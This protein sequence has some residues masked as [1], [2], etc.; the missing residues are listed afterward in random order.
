MDFQYISSMYDSINEDIFKS[1]FMVNATFFIK[2]EEVGEESTSLTGYSD[3]LDGRQ[4]DFIKKKYPSGLS[5]FYRV[6]VYPIGKKGLKDSNEIEQQPYGQIENYD[7]W[8]SCFTDT[9]KINVS[10][11]LLDYI[12]V[13]QIEGTKY[14][15]QS[16]VSESF[17]K[18]EVTHILLAKESNA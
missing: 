17:G 1:S 11:T 12:D 4:V 7:Y 8:V 5:P 10:N 15:V 9:I 18:K 6:K 3:F 2:A 13:V 16:V 14:T